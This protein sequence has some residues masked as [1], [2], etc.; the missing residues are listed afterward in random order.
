MDIVI[1]IHE[2]YET[3]ETGIYTLAKYDC[4]DD[5]RSKQCGIW[6]YSLQNNNDS[7]ETGFISY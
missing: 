3:Y 7:C 4:D 1:M 2:T 6:Q 5:F